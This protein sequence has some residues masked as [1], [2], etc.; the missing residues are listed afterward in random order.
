MTRFLT[1]I[2]AAT[3]AAATA[4]PALAESATIRIEPRPYYGAIVTI[5]QGVRVWRPL[6]TTKYVIINPEGRTPLN[7]GLTDIREHSTSHNHFYGG[8]ARAPAAGGGNTYAVPYAG[9]DR[10]RGHRGHGGQ[11]Q[12]GG[13]FKPANIR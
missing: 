1:A 6:P 8:E 13:G 10:G 11:K 2:T 9:V 3:L 12:R 4:A 5:E 7:L